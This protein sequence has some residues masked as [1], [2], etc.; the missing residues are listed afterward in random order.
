MEHTKQNCLPKERVEGPDLV[1][2]PK[3]KQTN[4]KKIPIV[5]TVSHPEFVVLKEKHDFK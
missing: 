4:K 5:A 1:V 3:N 2:L